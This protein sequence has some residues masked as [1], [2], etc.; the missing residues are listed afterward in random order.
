VPASEVVRDPRKLG[1]PRP[2]SPY[3]V[4]RD[5]RAMQSV[6]DALGFSLDFT[7]SGVRA[8]RKAAAE[9]VPPSRPSGHQTRSACPTQERKTHAENN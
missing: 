3:C 8:A 4:P 6:A 9:R 1:M 5:A 7:E 2:T